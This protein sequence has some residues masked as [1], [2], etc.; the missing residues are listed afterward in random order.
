MR[1]IVVLAVQVVALVGIGFGLTVAQDE[2]RTGGGEL[3]GTL[4]A[5]P[6]AAPVASPTIL[7]TCATPSVDATP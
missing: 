2:Q 5:S 4:L 1:Q 7:I 3:C 6:C